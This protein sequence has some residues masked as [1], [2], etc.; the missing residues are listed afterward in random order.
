MP[1]N[2]FF[3]PETN[4]AFRRICVT[5]AVCS[6]P[7]TLLTTLIHYLYT[8]P[9]FFAFISKVPFSYVS[10]VDV[11]Q[12]RVLPRK[13]RKKQQ[14]STDKASV[15]EAAGVEKSRAGH[16]L[17][18]RS[19]RCVATFQWHREF[20][21]DSSGFHP[22]FPTRLSSCI[23]PPSVFSCFVSLNII[24]IIVGYSADTYFPSRQYWG[25]LLC[26]ISYRD[27]RNL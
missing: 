8:F 6:E 9:Q 16:Q 18:I 20:H 3:D 11:A 23:S 1:H 19:A 5:G 12:N 17:V 24:L 25:A 14:I 4:E 13:K 26:I 2:W 15:S 21:H 7:T 27:L 22:F 10:R